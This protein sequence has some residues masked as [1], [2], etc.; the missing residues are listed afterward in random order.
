MRVYDLTIL[1][2]L[3]AVVLVFL[4]LQAAGS[5][6][7]VQTKSQPA[8]TEPAG[9]EKGRFMYSRR[10]YDITPLDKNQIDRLARDLTGQE[11]AVLLG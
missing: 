5:G 11:S 4:M 8:T 6:R 2:G 10:G 9:Q 3:G 7:G 1:G